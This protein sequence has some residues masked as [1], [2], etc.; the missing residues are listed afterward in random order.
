MKT[1]ERHDLTAIVLLGGGVVDATTVGELPARAVVIAADSGVEQAAALGLAVDVVVGDMDSLDAKVL[2][3][4]ESRGTHIERHPADKNETDAELALQLAARRGAS[5]IIVV[6]NGA[7]RLDHQLALFAVLFIDD[8]R[9]VQVEA[10]LGAARAIPVRA[11]ET[12]EVSCAP[13]SVVGLIPFGG[14]AHG[15]T[16][17]GLQWALQAGSLAAAASRGVSN[18]ATDSAFSVSVTRGR[19]IVTVDL[20]EPTR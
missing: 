3:M 10:R 16:T 6:G 20:A 13:G 9:T 4:L 7:G 17:H 15:V 5:R 8:L 14:D 18:R 2:A 11:G 19:L 1:N 12:V